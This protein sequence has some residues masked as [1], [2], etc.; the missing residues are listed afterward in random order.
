MLDTSNVQ[1]ELSMMQFL[2]VAE[3]GSDFFCWRIL[4]IKLGDFCGFFNS[5]RSILVHCIAIRVLA[6]S[7]SFC[8][9]T[10]KQDH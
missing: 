3:T 9:A 10:A 6:G 2:E 1:P 7:V 8:T 5:Y 4:G